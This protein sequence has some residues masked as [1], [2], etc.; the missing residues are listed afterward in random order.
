MAHH[1]VVENNPTK[2]TLTAFIG[3]ALLLT[4]IGGIAVAG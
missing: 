3:I 2:E 1:D 4:I